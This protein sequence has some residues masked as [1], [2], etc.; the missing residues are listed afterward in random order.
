MSSAITLAGWF[1]IFALWGVLSFLGA[2][3]WGMF[4]ARRDRNRPLV[5]QEDW[6]A[7]HRRADAERERNWEWLGEWEWTMAELDKCKPAPP[8]THRHR[9]P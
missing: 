2:M 3:C 8:P 6:E 5:N 7:K 4:I 9:K 1:A